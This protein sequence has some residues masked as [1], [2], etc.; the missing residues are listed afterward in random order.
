ML[1]K[2]EKSFDFWTE[3][4]FSLIKNRRIFIMSGIV[5]SAWVFFSILSKKKFYEEQIHVFF[6]QLDGYVLMDNIVMKGWVL[7]PIAIYLFSIFIEPSSCQFLIRKTSRANIL[8]IEEW[9]IVILS[10]YLILVQVITIFTICTVLCEERCNWMQ[11]YSV[12]WYETGHTI[13][14]APIFAYVVFRFCLCNFCDYILLGFIYLL[15]GY[16]FNQKYMAY[17]IEII[18]VVLRIGFRDYIGVDG[19]WFSQWI[20]RSYS[21]QIYQ[22]VLLI[23]L[24]V[25]C[26]K[27]IKRKDFYCG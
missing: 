17:I 11:N 20:S 15:I 22:I 6:C 18:I 10:L 5:F 21:A 27:I 13:K 4:K 1:V 7:F 24:I 9:K 14:E 2:K 26:K 3:F 19:V 16:G 23:G 8:K 12:F 25:A